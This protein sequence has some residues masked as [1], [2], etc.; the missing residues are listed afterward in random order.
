M[1]KISGDFFEEHIEKIV[2][3]IIGVVCMWLLLTRV[4]FSPNYVSFD[5]TKIGTGKI[6]MYISRQAE[7]L[8]DKL[9]QESVEVEPY[10]GRFNGIAALFDSAI[11]VDA[12]IVLP[13]QGEGRMLLND[14]RK[15]R[16]PVVCGINDVSVEYIR[17]VV[18]APIEEVRG[19]V[20]Y[21]QSNSEPNDLDFVTVEGRIDVAG[22]Y[23][24]F[25]ESFMGEDVEKEWRDPCLACPVF[26]AVELQRQELLS[27]GRWSDWQ[28]VPRTRID[29]YK[30]M[31]KII[32]DVDKLPRGGI[33]IRTL[34]YNN[35]MLRAN[36]LQPQGYMIASAE[37]E[38]FPPSLHKDYKKYQKEA[39]V[40]EKRLVR[41]AEKREKERERKAAIAERRS[42]AGD[43]FGSSLS[44]SQDPFGIAAAGDL[45][46]D[47]TSEVSA[48]RELRKKRREERLMR[49][50][51]RDGTETET[52]LERPRR[53][54]RRELKVLER[55][56][57]AV[58]PGMMLP[59]GRD[60]ES[61]INEVYV[62]Y[63]GLL[64]RPDTDLEKMTEP[65]VF[66][67]HDDTVRPDNSYRYGIR[68]G[69]FNPVAGT[70]QFVQEDKHMKNKAILWSDFAY[71]DDIVEV[72]KR[73]Y[74]FPIG[75][76]ETSET[77]DVEVHKYA[78]GYWYS[79]KFA[80]K[81]GEVIGKNVRVEIKKDKKEPEQSQEEITMPEEIDY[82]TGAV[83]VD[84]TRVNDWAGGGTKLRE[85][86]YYDMLYSFDGMNI[87]HLPV[88]TRFW[89]K[90]LLA[91]FV[92]IKK[93]G[94]EPKQPLRPWGS[95]TGGFRST[96]PMWDTRQRDAGSWEALF[97]DEL[98]DGF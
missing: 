83:V 98:M 43:T 48:S 22:L 35:P 21:D 96:R 10:R 2:F 20:Y 54:T 6:D 62:N 55:T 76:K 38:W 73:L 81:K 16:I 40:Q 60:A 11:S 93:M 91:K 65:L 68:L 19:Q 86:R 24:R 92:E 13:I 33:E 27:D 41:D 97:S 3:A 82:S 26:A 17:A 50:R 4:L 34:Q 69:V 51:D 85:R 15:Y 52:G 53:L 95:R 30:S 77:V 5:N 25:R 23:E 39:K 88:T 28:R 44:G 49:L 61:K 79:E 32:E 8:E 87:E 84:V 64:I 89:D 70:N 14:E 9:H 56:G 94:R 42:K 29:G 59:S 31:L 72:P 63:E 80:V 67:A 57:G 75:I 36:L 58:A 45:G 74:F 78:L 46:S 66:W 12:N 71:V 37:D 7:D 47:T 90:K 18:Y 1:F